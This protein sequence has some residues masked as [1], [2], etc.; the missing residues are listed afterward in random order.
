MQPLVDWYGNADTS[1]LV[2]SDN[3]AGNEDISALITRAA[4]VY[5]LSA[6][7]SPLAADVELASVIH[8]ATAKGLSN[9]NLSEQGSIAEV[10][11]IGSDS[12]ETY[13]LRDGHRLWCV[14]RLFGEWVTEYEMLHGRRPTRDDLKELLDSGP[15]GDDMSLPQIYE[16]ASQD[17][18]AREVAMRDLVAH[19]AEELRSSA[20]L[21]T[22]GG[23]PRDWVR[24]ETGIYGTQNAVLTEA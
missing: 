24:C 20:L 10:T 19:T 4:V 2:L 13:W 16:P 23:T 14:W 8:K 3:A 9:V 15:C 12:Q 1:G 6:E 11:S 5:A 18:P 7:G 22:L 17:S 21:Y